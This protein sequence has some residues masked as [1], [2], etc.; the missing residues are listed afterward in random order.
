LVGKDTNHDS[1]G[2]SQLRELVESRKARE[3]KRKMFMT[4]RQ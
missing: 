4:S 1:P 2:A 3:N